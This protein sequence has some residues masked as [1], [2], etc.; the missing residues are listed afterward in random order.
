[1]GGIEPSGRAGQGRR[2]LG[3]GGL[4]GV[5]YLDSGS[6]RR[7][8]L[9][10]AFAFAPSSVISFGL[11]KLRS[12]TMNDICVGAGGGQDVMRM[13]W[14]QRGPGQ[15]WTDLELGGN[16]ARAGGSGRVVHG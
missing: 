10:L 16:P 8:C 13:E 1:V 3:G 11:I 12:A 14:M 2:A 15:Y 7:L 5:R 9:R 4:N 6:T